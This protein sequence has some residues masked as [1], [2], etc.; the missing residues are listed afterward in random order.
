MELPV[1]P[2]PEAAQL[3]QGS[4]Q[5]CGALQMVQQAVLAVRLVKAGVQQIRLGPHTAVGY[6]T[7]IHYLSNRQV[8]YRYTYRPIPTVSTVHNI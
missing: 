7:Y 2:A 8:P 1:C 3:V 5:G 4:V 6:G